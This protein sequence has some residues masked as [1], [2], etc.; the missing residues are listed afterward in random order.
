MPIT[1]RTARLKDSC[2]YKH[3]VSGEFVD[4]NSNAGMERLRL[5]TESYKST[6]AEPEVMRRAKALEHLLKNM[7]IVIQEDELIVGDH[8]EHPDWF[9]LYPELGYFQIVDFIESEYIPVGQEDEAKEYAEF[10]KPLGLQAKAEPFCTEQELACSYQF[11]PTEPPTFVNAYT[12]LTP[13][14]ETVLEDGL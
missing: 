1:E 3:F 2:R 12:N 11:T 14:Y 13:P 4:P 6:R 10:W 8:A 5:F 9:P 7:T